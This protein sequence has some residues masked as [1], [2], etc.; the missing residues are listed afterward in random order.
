[1]GEK[2]DEVEVVSTTTVPLPPNATPVKA[3]KYSYES[4]E[5]IVNSADQD[6]TGTGTLYSEY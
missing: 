3:W 6:N 1:V 4:G 5:F 2:D